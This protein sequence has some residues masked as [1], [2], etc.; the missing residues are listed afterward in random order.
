MFKRPL[1]VLLGVM[2]AS[3]ASAQ[4]P[5]DGQGLKL[6][7][8]PSASE[9][10][11]QMIGHHFKLVTGEIE[12]AVFFGGYSPFGY[13]MA[14]SLTD[15]PYTRSTWDQAHAYCASKPG[16]WR[17]PDINEL[18]VISPLADAPE[19]DYLAGSYWTTTPA[20]CPDCQKPEV[21]KMAY[22]VRS[23]HIRNA[24]TL[25]FMK[26]YGLCMHPIP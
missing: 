24:Y 15:V 17:V 7:E 4:S 5:A 25:P 6:P 10:R 26:F 2:A 20:P 8:L 1:L 19:P 21:Y 13:P 3:A 16:N 14:F 18:R 22:D 11:P 12:E 9:L 23:G